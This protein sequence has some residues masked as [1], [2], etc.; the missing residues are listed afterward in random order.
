MSYSYLFGPVPS[1]RLGVSLG[2][3]MIPYKYCPF[4]C[5]YCECGATT[6]KITERKIFIPTQKIAEELEH[7]IKHQDKNTQPDAI[8]FSGSGEPTLAAN[9]GEIINYIKKK[10]L[11]SRLALI[12]NSYLLHDK[13]LQQELLPLDIILP[14]LD[15]VLQT[16]FDKINRPAQALSVNKIIQGLIDFR[17]IFKGQMLLEIFVI[18]GI[19]TSLEEMKEFKKVVHS[20]SPD[21][22]QLN[23]LDRPGTVSDLPKPTKEILE[24][25]SSALDYPDTEIIGKFS[26]SEHTDKI[27]RRTNE[28]QLLETLKRR[29]CTIADLVETLKISRTELEIQLTELSEKNKINVTVEDRGVFYSFKNG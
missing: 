17:K 9:L 18:P 27:Q 19:N 14:S 3:D 15:A 7:Y 8:S 24:E 29:P 26:Y 25:F 5:L 16:T 10:Q 12:T 23:S 4:D 1:R 6:H 13:D 21:K 28:K 11:R 20:I 22:V 2:I